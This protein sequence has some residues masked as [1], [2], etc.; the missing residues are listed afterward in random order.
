DEA[1]C[2]QLPIIYAQVQTLM[3][4]GQTW[5]DLYGNGTSLVVMNLDIGGGTSDMS[6]I[7]YQ[8]KSGA[9]RNAALSCKVLFRFG[10]NIAGDM[11]VKSIIEKVLLPAWIKASDKG[12]YAKNPQAAIALETLFTNPT[13]AVVRQVDPFMQRK[14]ARITRLVLAPLAN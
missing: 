8:N 12:L 14:L 9:S 1:V 13:F 3:N 6:I 4:D 2:S 7:E 10:S 11:I 5:I